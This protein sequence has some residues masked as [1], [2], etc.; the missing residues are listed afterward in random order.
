MIEPIGTELR[1]Q[2]LA[3]TE[4]Y[5]S[6]AQSTFSRSFDRIPVHFDLS[7]ST[8][9]MFRVHG[10]KREIRYNPWIFSKY[11]RENLAGTVPH[12]VAHYIVHRV[13]NMHRVRPHGAEWQSLMAEFDEASC[14]L[15]PLTLWCAFDSCQGQN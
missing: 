8:A 5:I 3:R 1:Q 14:S 7:G 4:F 10:R 9:G 12:E 15:V 11:Y 6:E 13:Y 2:V